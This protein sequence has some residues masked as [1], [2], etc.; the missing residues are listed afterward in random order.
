FLHGAHSARSLHPFLTR[1]SSDLA[2]THG[3]DDGTEAG[4]RYLALAQREILQGQIAE[5][6]QGTLALGGHR[7]R[8]GTA[9]GA[10]EIGAHQFP[11]DRKS[12]RLNSSHVKISY[13]VFCL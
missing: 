1:R 12:T 9:A 10:H 8:R 7:L 4:G 5:I 6:G 13:A 2:L 3:S 11:G